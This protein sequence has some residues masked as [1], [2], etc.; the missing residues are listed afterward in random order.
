MILITPWDQKLLGAAD[1][2]A[3]AGAGPGRLG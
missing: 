3:A 2:A 1:A